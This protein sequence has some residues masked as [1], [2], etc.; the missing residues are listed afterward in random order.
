M[1][2]E[3]GHAVRTCSKDLQLGG[4]TWTCS[5][6]MAPGHAAWVCC[7]DINPWWTDAM[8]E[9]LPDLHRILGFL[10]VFI[11]Y[12]FLNIETFSFYYVL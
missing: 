4:A 3:H 1:A 8:I 6:D 2:I 11:F 9:K 10:L 12:Q 7:K 5:V